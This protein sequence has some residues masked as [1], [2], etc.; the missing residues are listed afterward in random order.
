MQV[1]RAFYSDLITE[2]TAGV[3]SRSVDYSASLDFDGWPLTLASTA[4]GPPLANL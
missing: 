2:V 4:R 1:V 3:K